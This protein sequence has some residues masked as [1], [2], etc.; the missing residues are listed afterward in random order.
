M[1]RPIIGLHARVETN[2]DVS[3]GK[4]TAIRLEGAALEKRLRL[5]RSKTFVEA[6]TR[7]DVSGVVANK[8]EVQELIDKIANEFPE[9]AEIQLPLG[10]VSRC[11][12]GEPYEVHTLSRNLEIVEHFKR[13]EPLP[14]GLE[15]ARRLALHPAYAYIEVYTNMMCAVTE[16][17]D[18]SMIK[19]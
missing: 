18:V 5:K 12:L 11:Y 19:E 2:L 4:Q 8:V 3:P 17:G 13:G 1:R 15:K 6:M 16:S 10:I 7:L 14:D 9:L